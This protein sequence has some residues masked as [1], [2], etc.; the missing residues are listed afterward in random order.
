MADKE[1][2]QKMLD[3]LIS[4]NSSEM[5]AQFHQYVTDKVKGM[6]NPEPLEVEV[7][8]GSEKGAE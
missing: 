3:A 2:L 5:E 6:I 8:V 7:E 4:D 1:A